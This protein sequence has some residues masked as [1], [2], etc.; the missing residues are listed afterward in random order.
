M[1][2]HDDVVVVEMGAHGAGGVL[3]M[4]AFSTIHPIGVAAIAK[5]SP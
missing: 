2:V 1:F 5:L 4:G 3:F